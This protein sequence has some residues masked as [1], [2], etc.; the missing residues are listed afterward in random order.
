[1]KKLIFVLILCAIFCIGALAADEPTVYVSGFGNDANPG[2][3]DLPLKTLQAGFHALPFG[4]KLV[5]VTAFTLDETTNEFPET[6]GLVTLTS[7]DGV[8]DYRSLYGAKLY[9]V[10]Q[11]M[12]RG[13]MKFENIDFVACDKDRVIICN[14]HYACF[15]EGINCSTASKDIN[16]IGITGGGNRRYPAKGSTIEIHSGDW[17]RIRGGQR[18]SDLESFDGDISIAIY[19]GTFHEMVW[20]SGDIFTN[21]NASLFI[22]GGT[23]KSTVRLAN[24][25]GFSGDVNLSIY[26]GN[27]EKLINISNGGTIQGNVTV[28]ALA[29]TNAEIVKTKG[30]VGGNIRIDTTH[31][32]N[33]TS[34]F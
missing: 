20:L 1:M 11:L 2:T 3:K 4:G 31:P 16:L 21:G 33:I 19:G 18:S 29:K 8:T 6:D 24:T 25:Q 17:F 32:I 12:L 15:G 7:H 28:T 23:F 26:G 27:F 34:S 5:M 14:N 30:S 22:F 9:L 10:G 13:D